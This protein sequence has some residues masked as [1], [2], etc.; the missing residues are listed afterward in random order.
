MINGGT[1]LGDTR[2]TGFSSATAENSATFDT[3]TCDRGGDLY[4]DGSE[5]KTGSTCGLCP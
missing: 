5:T 3:I 1:F 4:C 2:M